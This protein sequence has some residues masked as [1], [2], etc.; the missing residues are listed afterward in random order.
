MVWFGFLKNLIRLSVQEVRVWI[1][2]SLENLKAS[3]GFYEA[4]NTFKF[5]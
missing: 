3:L 4:S 2:I 1:L 5:S